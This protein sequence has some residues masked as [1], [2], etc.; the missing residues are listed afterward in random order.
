[1]DNRET[2][3]KF[4]EETKAPFVFIPDPEGKVVKLYDVKA[5][6][7]SYAKRTSFVIGPDR[8]IL[9]VQTGSEAVDPTG[10]I[11]AC[12]LPKKGGP[13]GKPQKAS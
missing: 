2:L 6:E 12:P 8:K 11:E 3:A 7:V 5:P 9:K 10:A 13:A 4:K 1:M